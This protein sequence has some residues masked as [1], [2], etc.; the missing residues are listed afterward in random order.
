MHQQLEAEEEE[1]F[2]KDSLSHFHTKVLTKPGCSAKIDQYR[3]IE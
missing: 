3:N 2:G 1:N